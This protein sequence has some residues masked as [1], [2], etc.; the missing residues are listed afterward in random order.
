[1]AELT[2][3]ENERVRD[4]LRKELERGG[5]V[6]TASA[7]EL[8]PAAMLAIANGRAHASEDVACKLAMLHGT[9]LEALLGRAGAPASPLP[10]RAEAIALAR[11]DGVSDA[12]LAKV[13]SMDA[14]GA[15]GRSL[16]DWMGIIRDLDGSRAPA[17]GPL[18]VPSVPQPALM[19]VPT[20]PPLHP[21]ALPMSSVEGPSPTSLPLA[22]APLSQAL[23]MLPLVPPAPPPASLVGTPTPMPAVLGAS[24]LAAAVEATLS[25]F[26][27]ASL[28]MGLELLPH[29]QDDVYA[30]FGLMTESARAAELAHWE[31]HLRTSS[32]D[33]RELPAMRER[34]RM[35]WL[36]FDGQVRAPSAAPPPMQREASPLPATPRPDEPPIP[37]A[38]YAAICAELRLTPHRSED[39]FAFYGLADPSQRSVVAE[40]WEG[41]RRT[42]PIED[43]EF[44]RLFWEKHQQLEQLAMRT[45][46]A[47]PMPANYAAAVKAVAP[48][49]PLPPLTLDVD[50]YALLC[51]RLEKEKDKEAVYAWFGLQKLGERTALEQEWQR[52]LAADPALK[53]EWQRKKD[54]LGTDWIDFDE[55]K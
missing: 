37:L 45:S 19:S 1:M 51:L 28:S 30:S 35:H 7:L 10:K 15:A 22:P 9:T 3:D 27:Y 32:K 2:A 41:R 53:A 48:S 5:I 12:V 18:E 20:A 23:P 25:I 16:L 13:E 55:F 49:G 38:T 17:A 52:R 24:A 26:E 14:P 29:R 4:A 36:R 43:Q 47:A 44:Q 34:M 40:T 8:A 46:T 21:A 50:E 42:N 39:I 33:R 54:E 31:A 6:D 11:K